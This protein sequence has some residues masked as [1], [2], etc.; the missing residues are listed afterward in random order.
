[1]SLSLKIKRAIIVALA[2]KEAGEAVATAATPLPHIAPIGTTTNLRVDTLANLGADAEAR[3]DA[4]EGKV[5]TLLT[6]LATAGKM[7]AA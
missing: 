6:A 3:L 1:M 4:L 7:D 5:D 2:S